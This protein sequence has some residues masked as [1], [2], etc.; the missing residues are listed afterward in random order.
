MAEQFLEQAARENKLVLL[1][2]GAEWCSTCHLVDG[3]LEKAWPRLENRLLWVKVDIHQRPDLVERFEVLSVPTI[4]LLS[5]EEGV[6]WRRSGYFQPR[7]IEAVLPRQG[8]LWLGN[9]HKLTE[10]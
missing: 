4:F 6:L 8:E 2:F 9:S 7:E 1:D 3:I 5:P 10:E